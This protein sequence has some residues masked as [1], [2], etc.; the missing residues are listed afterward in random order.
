MLQCSINQISEEKPIMATA[1]TK[2]TV[3]PEFDTAIDAGTKVAETVI[4]ANTEACKKG[5]ETM[6]SM[7]R[8]A[9][10]NAT[11]ASAEVKGFEKVADYPKAN[12]EAFAEAGSI[13][14]RGIEAWNGRV[15]EAAKTQFEDGLAVQKALF[16]A[17]TF[18]EA[19]EIQQGFVRKATERAMN[20]GAAIS[21][22]WM[23][24]ASDAAA[25]LTAQAKKTVEDV[26][27][28]AA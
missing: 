11:K 14:V 9:I 23:K 27:K 6:V 5:Y 15:F 4:K 20:D 21:G 17:K 16:G 24:L 19:V 26:T 1:K 18:Q 2:E 3:A 13:F 22:A 7:G 8:E 25:P 28:T 12:F 10:D